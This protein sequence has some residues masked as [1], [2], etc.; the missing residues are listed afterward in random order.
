MYDV[1]TCIGE[2]VV[3]KVVDDDELTFAFL[4]NFF[5]CFLLLMCIR[6]FFC[7]LAS[8]AGN[9]FTPNWDTPSPLMS[10]FRPFSILS[11]W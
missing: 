11:D 7:G 2:E 1:F 6:C 3:D 10:S 5:L 8:D 9:G 4:M